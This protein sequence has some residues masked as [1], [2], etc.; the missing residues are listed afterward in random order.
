MTTTATASKLVTYAVLAS[1][2]ESASKL[3]SYAALGSTSESITKLVAYAVLAVP[4]TPPP[5]TVVNLAV[6]VV[7]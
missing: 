5:T 4:A 1:A 3:V 7:T 2:S 6:T